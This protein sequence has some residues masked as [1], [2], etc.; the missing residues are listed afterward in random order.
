MVGRDRRRASFVGI[1]GTTKKR[2]SSE[3]ALAWALACAEGE[4][5]ET[6]LLNGHCLAT[7]PI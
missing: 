3:K 1:G 5:A 6:R 2:S 7:L 4:G